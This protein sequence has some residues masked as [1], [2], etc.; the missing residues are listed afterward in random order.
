MPIKAI[1]TRLINLPILSSS[2]MVC[3]TVLV[4]ANCKITL[5][6]ISTIAGRENNKKRDREKIIKPV[7]SKIGAIA[8]SFSKPYICDLELR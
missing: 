3:K 2:A 5:K 6:P 4:E 8:I 7:P 1:E